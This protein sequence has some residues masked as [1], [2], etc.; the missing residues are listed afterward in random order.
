MRNQILTAVSL[1]ALMVG[2][3]ATAVSSQSPMP[4]P[5]ELII[6]V[7]EPDPDP[8]PKFDL[9]P[10]VLV[11]P[12]IPEEP[13]FPP[14]DDPEPIVPDFELCLNLEHLCKPE[15]GD[16]LNPTLPDDDGD[17][18]DTPG[19]EEPGDDDGDDQPQ[20]EEPGDDQPEQ[21][22]DQPDPEDPG[23]QPEQPGDDDEDA[24][25]ETPETGDGSPGNVVP[26]DEG[27]V[28]PE[29]DIDT[30]RPGNPSFTG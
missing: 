7:P 15:I 24:T 14:E 2:G 8:K 29:I 13:P 28:D 22:E 25:P 10:F 26:Q 23:D 4:I 5:D 1:A 30:P 9:G 11:T 18:G 12:T 20:P 16:L 19:E 3:V 21:P 17:D 27:P 6:P